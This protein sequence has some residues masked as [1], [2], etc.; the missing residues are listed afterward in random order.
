MKF[1]QAKKWG[2]SLQKL[3]SYNNLHVLITA[4]QP[5]NLLHQNK[6][7]L[8]HPKVRFVSDTVDVLMY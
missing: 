1:V 3:K 4:Y 2:I 7:F 5:A 6:S 8:F